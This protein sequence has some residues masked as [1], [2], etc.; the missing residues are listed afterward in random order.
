MKADLD[1]DAHL[2]TQMLTNS[3]DA[4][5]RPLNE[6]PYTFQ[7][8]FTWIARPSPDRRSKTS[9]MNSYQSRWSLQKCQPFLPRF[10][11][12]SG[13]SKHIHHPL[14]QVPKDLLAFFLSEPMF[15]IMNP[16][17]PAFFSM[18]VTEEH[19]YAWESLF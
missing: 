2:P 15:C 17:F 8:P 3:I 12:I 19:L 14:P 18:K 16:S 6:L 7:V 11:G 13:V 10:P 4:K 1:Q 5:K 9:E